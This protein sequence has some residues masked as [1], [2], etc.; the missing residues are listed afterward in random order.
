MVN[1]AKRWYCIY[2]LECVPSIAP[3]VIGSTITTI[4]SLWSI[5]IV[6]LFA[7]FTPRRNYVAII[8]PSEVLSFN[9]SLLC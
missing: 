2:N 5:Y 1:D 8:M 4:K 9:S 7:I 3:S 6:N